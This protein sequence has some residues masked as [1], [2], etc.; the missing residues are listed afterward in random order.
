MSIKKSKR[1]DT[2]YFIEWLG[3]FSRLSRRY[4]T[5]AIKSLGDRGCAKGLLKVMDST[6]RPSRYS[7]KWSVLH[8]DSQC[9]RQGASLGQRKDLNGQLHEIRSNRFRVRNSVPVSALVRLQVAFNMRC[10]DSAPYFTCNA[11]GSLWL[12]GKYQCFNARSAFFPSIGWG[13]HHSNCHSKL[14]TLKRP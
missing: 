8:S 3:Q 13:M 9:S 1:Q 14:R 7:H 5:I 11:G 10:L 6:F 12:R 2:V 4:V